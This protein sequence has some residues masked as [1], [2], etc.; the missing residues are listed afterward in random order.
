MVQDQPDIK[1]ETEQEDYRQS[2]V[3]DIL[4][5]VTGLGAALVL[6]WRTSDLVWGLWLSSLTIGYATIL[7]TIGSGLIIGK[8]SLDA[9]SL[10][11]GSRNGI[12]VAGIFGG[13]FLLGFFT[14]H[15]GMFHMVHAIFLGLFFTP[16]GLAEKGSFDPF[17]GPIQIIGLL[18]DLI[19]NYWPMLV[20]TLIAERAVVFGPLFRALTYRPDPAEEPLVPWAAMEHTVDSEG[21]SSS[22]P[23]GASAHGSGYRLKHNAKLALNWGDPFARPYANVIRM[24]LLIFFFAFAHAIKLDNLFVYAVV[25]AVYFFPWRLVLGSHKSMAE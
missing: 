11:G 17:R 16:P 7:S 6:G 12:V 20:A 13:L 9:S 18:G 8:K 23:K 22:Q 19:R 2:Y 25:Y 4:A 24:H 21:D 1:F 14:F 3:P 10:D 15:F 5:F